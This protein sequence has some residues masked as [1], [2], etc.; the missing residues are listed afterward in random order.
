MGI[1][2]KYSNSLFRLTES[3]PFDMCSNLICAFY[4][5][6]GVA[7]SIIVFS[8]YYCSVVDLPSWYAACDFGVAPFIHFHVLLIRIMVSIFLITDRST[9]GLTLMMTSFLGQFSKWY[10]DARL[11]FY[12]V[13]SCACHVVQHI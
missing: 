9:I 13:F 3:E 12:W 10:K 7:F 4:L 8:V 6:V 2:S 11:Y 1:S 5:S